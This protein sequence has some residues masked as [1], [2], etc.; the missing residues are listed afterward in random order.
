[1]ATKQQQ[2]QTGG[3]LGVLAAVVIGAI[4]LG[5]GGGKGGGREDAG[6]SLSIAYPSHLVDAGAGNIYNSATVTC[7]SPPERFQLVVS[8]HYKPR[9]G[10]WTNI[11]E[12]V[13]ETPPAPRTMTDALAG[14]L[15]GG[16]QTRARASGTYKGKPISL[17]E[18]TPMRMV[19]EREC[20]GGLEG[21]PDAVA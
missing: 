17:A 15:P 10:R 21:G 3:G 6:C 9:G 2:S 13:S 8:L 16:W 7:P 19:T 20:A 11:D 1:M 4:A 18:E 12:G 5:G 14:C